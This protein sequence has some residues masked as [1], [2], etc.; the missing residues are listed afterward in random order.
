[1]LF[2]FGWVA[3][4]MFIDCFL[5]VCWWDFG[6]VFGFVDV[7]DFVGCWFALLLGFDCV[8]LICCVLIWCFSL[9]VDVW[10]CVE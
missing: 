8:Y 7:G 5:V 1:M 9:F 10:L 2:C 4:V 6:F 3:L